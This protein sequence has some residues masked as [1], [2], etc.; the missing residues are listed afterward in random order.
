MT[1][2]KSRRDGKG[3]VFRTNSG[4]WIAQVRTYDELTGKS[5]QIRRRAKSRD[6]ARELLT[7][8]Q[9]AAPVPADSGITL[10]DYFRRW[11]DENLQH[12]GVAPRTQQIYRQCLTDYGIPAAGRV[13]LTKFTPSLA[14]RWLGGV[15]A[16]R[17]Y[18]IPDPDTGKRK[19][20]GNPI[21]ASTVRNTYVAAVKALDAAVR[22]GLLET[23]SLR[24]VDRPT[25]SK[26]EVPVTTPDQVDALLTTCEG[27]R[28]EALVWFVAWTGCRIGEA[29]A[30]RWKDVDLTTGIA[31]IRRSSHVGSSTKTGKI[32]DVTLL[33]E[34]VEQ[35]K[36]VRRRT[37]EERLA[38]GPGWNDSGLV[39]TSGTGQPL[40]RANVTHQLQRALRTAGVTTER[41]WHS[42][43]HGYASRLLE[44]G[45]P[46][47]TVS[48]LLGHSGIGITA[49]IY[50]HVD[51]RVPVGVLTEVLGR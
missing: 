17:K 44:R 32:R 16:T 36:S 30:L 15:R 9:S 40:D 4:Q 43:R 1:K 33:P 18:G 46:L 2:P 39:F 20:D 35:L 27:R 31:T 26:V 50:G 19:R 23:N 28:I 8:L 51:S 29:L 21:A 12:T 49:D 6:H 7:E 13:R 10:A 41:P 24:A 45:L 5:R 11:C 25:V 48:A 38:L 37:R 42:L 22:D 34:V 3:S 47:P 14:E